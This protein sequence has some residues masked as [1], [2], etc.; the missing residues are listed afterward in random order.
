[1]DWLL[2]PG[3]KG[4]DAERQCATTAPSAGRMLLRPRFALRIL[5]ADTAKPKHKA[6]DDQSDFVRVCFGYNSA[7]RCAPRYGKD[8]NDLT[9]THLDG[10]H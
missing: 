2:R 8:K 1:M 3:S 9:D 4:L 7:L 5:G 6:T 10:S